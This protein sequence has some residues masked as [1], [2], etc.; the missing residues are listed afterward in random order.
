MTAIRLAGSGGQGIQL[1]AVI[2]GEAATKAGFFVACSQNY[3]PQ[4]RGGAS[5]ADVILSPVEIDYPKARRLDILVALS[6]KSALA[7]MA[8]LDP[9]G[10]ALFD[11]GVEADV[12]PGISVERLPIVKTAGDLGSSLAAGIVALGVVSSITGTADE[13]AIASAMA[14]RIRRTTSRNREALRAGFRL[15]GLALGR[16]SA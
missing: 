7:S 13:E 3:G 9:S 5:R 4:S 16:K 2:L 6:S 15:G 10:L 14:A 1:A 11:L 12:P 8:E